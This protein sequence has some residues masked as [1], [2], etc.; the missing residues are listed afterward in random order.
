MKK[1]NGVLCFQVK[2]ANSEGVWIVDAKNG[3]GSVSF[4]GPGTSLALA[5]RNP[6][7]LDS[8]RNAYYSI[9]I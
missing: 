9:S 2:G 3:N 4:G 8:K 5:I 1:I 6:Y 7:I